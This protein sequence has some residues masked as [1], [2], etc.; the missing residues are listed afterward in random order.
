M[1]SDQEKQQFGNRCPAGYKKVSILGKGGIALVWLGV[2]NTT[3]QQVAMKQFPKQGGKFDSSAGVEIQIQ[4][5]LQDQMT[6]TPGGDNVC[7]LLDY[8]EDKKDLF[9]IYELCLGKTMNEHLF[10]VKGEFYK[11]ER[12]YLVNHSVFYHRIRNDLRLM[13]DFIKRMTQMLELFYQAGVVHADLKPDNILI[14][15]DE[16]TSL[17][18]CLKIIDLGSAFLLNRREERLKDQIEFGQSTPEY[19][20]PEIQTYLT[21]KFT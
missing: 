20:P 13:A 8:V 4:A 2:S 11:G 9:L 15:Y 10:D 12:I 19:L 6:K 14:D 5:R 21:R 16:E 1:L 17:I 3:G 18:K 7:L